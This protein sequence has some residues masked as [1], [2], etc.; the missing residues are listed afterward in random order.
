MTKTQN[1]FQLKEFY[2]TKDIENFGEVPNTRGQKIKESF[3]TRDV[4][5]VLKIL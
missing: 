3:A 4:D 5:E 1:T 2:S